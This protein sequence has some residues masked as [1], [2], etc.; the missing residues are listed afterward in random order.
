MPITHSRPR[1]AFVLG[2]L[3]LIGAPVVA[4]QTGS[5]RLR[6]FLAEVETLSAV[7]HQTVFDESMNPLEASSG[8]VHMQRPAKFRWVYETPYAQEIVGD[9][10]R[11]WIYDAD[12]EQVTVSA[13][14]T[15]LGDSPAMLLSSDRPI[16]E[17]FALRDLPP[18]GTVS[19]VELTPL[20][21]EATFTAIRLGFDAS[22]L[23]LMELLDGFGQLT[24]I[25]FQDLRI[26]PTLDAGL[27]TYAPAAG[28]DVMER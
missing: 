16:D 13:V 3:V 28:V 7:F 26:N 15:T 2:L 21:S 9:G 4:A 25:E 23:R 10:E 27:F 1:S 24:Q 19:W 11:V 6:T 12:L 14:D 5:E 20:G 17:S 18:Q 22:S 8:Q